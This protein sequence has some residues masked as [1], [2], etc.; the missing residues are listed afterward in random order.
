MWGSQRIEIP[1]EGCTSLPTV[2][3]VCLP[4][5]HFLMGRTEGKNG[6]FIAIRMRI[7]EKKWMPE[8]MP[9][10]LIVICICGIFA[11]VNVL[12]GTRWVP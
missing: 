7:H 6:S 4:A 3:P 12:R 11:T 1:G 9:K 2:K 5:S 8:A 10:F